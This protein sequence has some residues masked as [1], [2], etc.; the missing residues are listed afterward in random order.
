[1]NVDVLV[2]AKLTKKLLRL[3][4]RILEGPRVSPSEICSISFRIEIVK[5]MRE[6]YIEG[7]IF[8]APLT[9]PLTSLPLH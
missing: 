4:E 8:V 6:G 3:D 9:T 5:S 7:I 1:M 2:L